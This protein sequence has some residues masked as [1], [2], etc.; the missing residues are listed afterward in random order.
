MTSGTGSG[1]TTEPG[2]QPGWEVP[3][4]AAEPGESH[5]ET[6]RREAGEDPGGFEAVVR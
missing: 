4:G 5:L 6:C 1:R 2:P 3:G